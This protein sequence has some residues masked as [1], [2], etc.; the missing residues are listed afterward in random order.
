ME[1]GG[2]EIKGDKF[3]KLFV[4]FVQAKKLLNNIKIK[5]FRSTYF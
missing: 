2:G 1:G 3:E 5:L 4:Q